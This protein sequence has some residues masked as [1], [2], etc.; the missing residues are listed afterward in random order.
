[1]SASSATHS[2]APT[3]DK[4]ASTSARCVCET[5]AFGTA[6]VM[7][8]PI[9]AGV[10]G[11]ART[12]A[13][14]GKLRARNRNVRPAMMDTTTVAPPTNGASTGM[15]S[16]AVCG[17]TATTTAAT[18]PTASRDALRRRP[19]ALSAAISRLGCGSITAMFLGASPSASQ[20]QRVAVHDQPVL[21]PQVEMPDP[22][23]LVDQRDEL[24][25]LAAAA[26]RRFELEGAGE[27][28][29]LDVEHPGI[30]N[31]IVAPFAGH[32]DGDLVLA[33]A[34][35]RPA[36]GRGH[37]LHDLERVA[38]GLFDKVDEGHAGLHPGSGMRTRTPRRSL[39]RSPVE[40][41]D[42]SGANHLVSR[43]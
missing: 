20:H 39:T 13:A 34:L 32:Q 10:L 27:M 33:R 38:L 11:M 21:N 37:L 42:R 8:R 4:S 1:M 2:T 29:R 19:R 22:H 18:S 25:H 12:I 40:L 26:L 15:A 28:Q 3:A 36:V 17:L 5:R 31:L 14:P 35:E 6:T 24:L 41:I 23:L 30:G 9:A 43:I 16:S 7:P